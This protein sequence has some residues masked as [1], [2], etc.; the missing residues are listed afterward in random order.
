MFE[1]TFERPC[2]LDRPQENEPLTSL[3]HPRRRSGKKRPPQHICRIRRD[4]VGIAPN[5]VET[6]Q[7]SA[8]L[9]CKQWPNVA[10]IGPTS[11]NYGKMEGR[12]EQRRV[13]FGRA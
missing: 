9:G 5:M 6:E 3:L 4:L 7:S 11:N 1:R 10:D 12:V 13:E 8:E 2:S